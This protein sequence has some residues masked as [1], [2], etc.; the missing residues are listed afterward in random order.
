MATL[1]VV[2]EGWGL[3]TALRTS[4]HVLAQSHLAQIPEQEPLL[5][6]VSLMGPECQGSRIPHSAGIS[7]WKEHSVLLFQAFQ[8]AGGGSKTEAGGADMCRY[9]GVYQMALV[10]ET[11]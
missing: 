6:E 9:C 8:L 10:S 11:W 1:T 4:G 5:E 2:P 7:E 3:R